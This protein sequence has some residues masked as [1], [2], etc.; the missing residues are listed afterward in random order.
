MRL[1]YSNPR[2]DM[3]SHSDLTSGYSGNV[4]ESALDRQWERDGSRGLV[5]P[6]CTLIALVI[7]LLLRL[8]TSCADKH[9]LQLERLH[10][11]AT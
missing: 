1:T 11:V 2:P 5:S 6:Y 3:P 9:R 10:R 7:G 4:S 8:R